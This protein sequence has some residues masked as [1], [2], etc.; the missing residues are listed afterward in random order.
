MDHP[1]LGTYGSAWSQIGSEDIE[2]RINED[3]LSSDAMQ[4][5]NLQKIVD[6]KKVKLGFEV[7]RQVPRYDTD[8]RWGSTYEL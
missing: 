3:P 7:A 8:T 1:L 6:Q 5:S 4:K 2:P